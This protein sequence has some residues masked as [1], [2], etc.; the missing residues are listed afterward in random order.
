MM[1]Q[2]DPLQESQINAQR[3]V[4]HIQEALASTDHD[5]TQ[6]HLQEAIRFGEQSRSFLEETLDSTNEERVIAR[7]EQALESLEETLDQ[8]NQAIFASSDT[9]IEHIQHM[10][11]FGEQALSNLEMALGL[12]TPSSP[13]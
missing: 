10:Y 8:A 4:S 12:E 13:P 6:S 5:E 11:N 1:A 9:S 3:M 7:G 2:D